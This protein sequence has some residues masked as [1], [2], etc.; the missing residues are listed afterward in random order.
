MVTTFCS[1]LP[2]QPAQHRHPYCQLVFAIEGQG[3]ID[4]E[5][6][7]AP[8]HPLS[9]YLVSGDCWHA[10][11]GKQGN[12]IVVV[13]F[14]PDFVPLVDPTHPEHDRLCALI[15]T[16]RPIPLVPE[17]HALAKSAASSLARLGNDTL[18][19]QSLGT[20]LLRAA[21]LACSADRHP[22]VRCHRL[23]LARID[24]FIDAHLAEPITVTDLAN[25]VFLSP[26]WFQ[27][28]FKAITGETPLRYV[29]RRRL[30]RARTLLLETALPLH[31]IATTTGFADLS[32]FSHAF[33]RYFGYPPSR[34]RTAVSDKP[35]TRSTKPN[36]S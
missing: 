13:N 14:D 30:E 15:A 35:T 3:E 8:L 5:G 1:E 25:C 24:A 6:K 4:A 18:L 21:L 26:S 27:H 11:F 17:I 23:D 2:M 10:F 16:P 33:S 9:A 22:T 19:C 36:K 34:L 32:T 31:R 12:R 20:A 7:L 28:V 29:Q